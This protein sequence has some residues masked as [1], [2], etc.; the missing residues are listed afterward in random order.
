[1]RK[2]IIFHFKNHKELVSTAY[3]NHALT[4]CWVVAES[5]MA[6]SKGPSLSAASTL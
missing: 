4:A 2:S 5:M 1:M 6:G 3:L